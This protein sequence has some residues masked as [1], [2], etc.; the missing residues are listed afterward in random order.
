MGLMLAPFTASGMYGKWFSGP[1]NVD[2]TNDLVVLEL[3]SLDGKKELQS[4]VLFTLIY[5]VLREMSTLRGVRR[6]MFM[7]DEAHALLSGGMAGDFIE[8]GFRT[9]RKFGWTFATATQ[10]L[11]DYY[12][13]PGAQASLDNADW[14]LLLRQKEDAIENVQRAGR[15]PMNEHMKRMLL[16]LRTEK[17]QFSEVFVSSPMGS[18]VGRLLLDPFSLLL[19]SSTDDDYAAIR[20]R[21]DAGMTLV[22]AIEDL[23]RER[24]LS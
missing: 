4:V 19:F 7:I 24:G 18:G 17:G 20:R 22:D 5:R 15:L 23:M 2:L 9:A 12:K 1:A 10:G 11:N 3:Q 13:S 14:L 6:G 21:Q 16:S 8:G